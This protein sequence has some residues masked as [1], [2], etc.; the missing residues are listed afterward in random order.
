LPWG[1]NGSAYSEWPAA[2]QQ[3]PES[4]RFTPGQAL[5]SVL[6]AIAHLA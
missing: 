1:R 3:R 4:K 5:T 2:W 6:P